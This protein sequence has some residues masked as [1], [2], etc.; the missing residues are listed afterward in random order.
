LETDLKGRGIDRMAEGVKSADGEAAREAVGEL[1]NH[2]IKVGVDVWERE[3]DTIESI[4]ADHNGSGAE[5]VAG[6]QAT[7]SGLALCTSSRLPLGQPSHSRSTVVAASRTGQRYRPDE[8]VQIN[9]SRQFAAAA[10]L[11]S[12]GQEPVPNEPTLGLMFFTPNPAGPF[13]TGSWPSDTRA[14]AAA[15]WREP[16]I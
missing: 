4:I 13:G 1:D 10:A 11:V 16:L 6:P 9:G 8:P 2:R 3:E 14:A 15:N 5:G 7:R 12:D